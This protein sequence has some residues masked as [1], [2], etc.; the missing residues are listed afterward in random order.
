MSKLQPIADP[1][2]H[3]AAL[4]GCPASEV[5]RMEPWRGHAAFHTT[6]EFSRRDDRV[7]HKHCGPTAF[8]NLICT[9]R[10]RLG[11]EPVEPTAVFDRC[12]AI[13]RRR[14]L[15]WNIRDDVPVLGGTSYLLLRPYVSA[16]LRDFGLGDARLTWRLQAR[17]ERMARELEQGKLLVLG[18]TRHR[19]YGSHLVMACGTVYV[20]AADGSAPRLYL[21]VADGWSHRPR[22][23][24]A[25]TLRLCGYAAVEIRS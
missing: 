10:S 1:S 12:A 13:G 2:A 7:Y 24:A 14:L 25:D 15:Y 3:T 5:R 22:Y 9:L 21:L 16:C 17:P 11:M 18:M 20:A 8:T 4:T 23:I 19:C 6:G